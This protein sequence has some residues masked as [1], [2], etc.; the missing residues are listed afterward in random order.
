[1]GWKVR[2]G[3]LAG[4][5][6]SSEVCN[7]LMSTNTWSPK[8]VNLLGRGLELLAGA[9][10]VEAVWY[11]GGLW[12][13]I[14]WPTSCSSPALPLSPERLDVNCSATYH[15][16]F[17]TKVSRH[18]YSEIMGKN[19]SPLLLLVVLKYFSHS[20]LKLIH[21]NKQRIYISQMNKIPRH[22]RQRE[23]LKEQPPIT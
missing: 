20:D 21:K 13:C 9:A 19:I 10:L 1:M 23:L 18:L 22:T 12:E 14:T 16:T 11:R 2:E 5:R 15:Y 6:T 17:L 7:R 4:G 3:D 8:L